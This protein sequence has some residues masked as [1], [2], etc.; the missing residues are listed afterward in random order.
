[1]QAFDPC[2][3][4]GAMEGG[5]SPGREW[6][7]RMKSSRLCG[8]KVGGSL[9]CAGSGLSYSRCCGLG[10]EADGECSIHSDAKVDMSADPIWLSA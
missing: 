10:S 1:M 2:V 7:R 4:I 5:T 8:R 9:G 3:K 6:G